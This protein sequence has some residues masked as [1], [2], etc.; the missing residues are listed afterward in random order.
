M[1]TCLVEISNYKIFGKQKNQDREEVYLINLRVKRGEHKR[2]L[3][4]WGK[5]NL[6]LTE[7][8]ELKEDSLSADG[9]SLIC[10]SSTDFVVE[11]AS[12]K[13]VQHE[14]EVDKWS[15]CVS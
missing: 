14:G 1:A 6:P 10:S 12:K 9:V 8:E 7:V 2:N 11:I 13:K 15:E 4:V 3:Q 5:K